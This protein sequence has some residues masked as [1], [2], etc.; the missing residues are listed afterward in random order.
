MTESYRCSQ[1]IDPP[2]HPESEKPDLPF[3]ICTNGKGHYWISRCVTEWGGSA[4]PSN[5]G[6][7][8]SLPLEK[9]IEDSYFGLTKGWQTFTI[10]FLAW[11]DP[12]E[13]VPFE[14]KEK[15]L[16]RCEKEGY[17]KGKMSENFISWHHIMDKQPIENKRIVQIDRPVK[18]GEDDFK[19][20]YTM[21]L[22]LYKNYSISF[23]E[24]LKWCR[25]NNALFPDY[26]WCY[27]EDFPW[28][29]LIEKAK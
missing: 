21:G 8:V 18:Y 1:Q 26:W 3:V 20:H 25:E 19:K 6:W 4:T 29:D 2:W 15:E 5:Y 28:P 16:H 22:R 27:A 17:Y 10:P 12:R 7:Q 11:C 24:Y 13:F 14:R 23:D 9:G